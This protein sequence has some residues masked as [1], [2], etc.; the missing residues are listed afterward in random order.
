MNLPY[1]YGSY[2]HDL[3]PSARFVDWPCDFDLMK[4][5]RPLLEA[6]AL[7]LDAARIWLCEGGEGLLVD[8]TSV[9]GPHPKLLEAIDLLQEAAALIGVRIYWTLLDAN[10][11]ARDR[12]E[13][14]RAILVGG[15]A[16]T[17]FAA[18]VAAPIA[19]R[20][21]PKVTLG[22]EIVNE[23]EV[24]TDG[25]KDVQPVPMETVPWATVGG[26]I[27][28]CRAAVL[29]E[30]PGL[31]VTAGTGYA[32]LPEL[33]RSGAGLDAIDIHIYHES[34]GLPSRSDIAGYVG[35]PDLASDRVPIIAGECGV[36][37][38]HHDPHSLRNYLIN[39]DGSGYAAA[40]LWKLEGDLVQAKDPQRAFTQA[41]RDVH[42][43]LKKRPE[44]GF[45]LGPG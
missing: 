35:D 44:T 30:R 40:F 34:G 14:T 45:V 20:L 11:A 1:F 16:A 18:N 19:R 5:Y 24:V 12:D 21:D 2:G 43:E 10:S 28:T 23:P 29:A 7:G 39:A 32:F 31:L 13:I 15:D 38:P 4:A 25:C 6:K 27:A 33:W 8:G 41:G 22:L 37:K 42:D 26:A 36:T 17:R 9:T 3:A